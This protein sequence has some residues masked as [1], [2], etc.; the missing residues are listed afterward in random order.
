MTPASLGITIHTLILPATAGIPLIMA[1]LCCTPLKMRV[2]GRLPWAAV[3][4]LFVA[5]TAPSEVVVEVDWFFMGG[6]MGLDGTGRIF[7]FLAG[8]IWFLAS[9]NSRSQLKNGHNQVRFHI[10]FLTAMAGNFSLI[11]ARGIFGYY[12]FFAMMSFAAYGLVVHKENKDAVNAGRLYLFL[13]MIGEVALF[14]AL[15]ILVHSGGSLALKDI[16]GVSYTPLPLALLFVGFGI[17]IGVLPLHGWM[18][19]A[20]R[21]T[22]G[23]AAAALA[24]SMVNAGILGWLRFLPIG[25][26]SYPQGAVF[27]IVMGALAAVYGVIIGLTK[28][29]AGAILGGS[30]IS[31]MGLI[32]VIFG[33]GLVDRDAGLHAAPIV[34]PLCSPSFPGEKQPLLCL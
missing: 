14:T 33:M 1:A 30:S 25:Q 17:K 9:L 31:Q 6:H 18:I 15:I 28:K 21:T 8:F 26:I 20:Y 5:L 34:H 22:P 27:F 2:I 3:P 4:A 13:V 19:P 16:A 23:P 29:Q 10:F 11:L 7:L 24:G 12:L 32:T